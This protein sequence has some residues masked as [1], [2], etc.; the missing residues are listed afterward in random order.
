MIRPGVFRRSD[1]H[2]DPVPVAFDSPHS[3]HHYPADFGHAVSLDMLRRAEDAYVDEL[4]AAAPDHGAT[5]LAALFP[6]TYIDPN[7]HVADIDAE[8]IED[9]W[10]G[11]IAARSQKSRIGQGLLR[12]ELFYGMPVYERRLS[13]A[14]VRARI[15]DYY[16]PYH[17]ELDAILDGFA[18]DFGAVWHINC[19]SMKSRGKRMPPDG[20]RVR[21]PDISIG[22]RRGSACDPAFTELVTATLTALGYRVAINKP[23]QGAELIRRHGRPAEDRHSLQ[24]EINRALYMDE[25]T[26]EKTA[27]FER[28]QADLMTFT[29][30]VCAFARDRQKR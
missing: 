17:A 27:D 26:R 11:E 18:E 19:H 6:R 5:S 24:I 2:T 7:R 22:D 28:L 4:F 12:R 16:E 14:E 25:R 8:L 10:P 29:E 13:V 20:E 3:G 15:D 1:P 30:Q 23:Y 9:E 21:R